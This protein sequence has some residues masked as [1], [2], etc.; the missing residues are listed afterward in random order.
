MLAVDFFV[1]VIGEGDGP[2]DSMLRM[3][4]YNSDYLLILNRSASLEFILRTN[5]FQH[6]GFDDTP[7]SVIFEW[8]FMGNFNDVELQMLLLFRCVR[9]CG[10]EPLK[11]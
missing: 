11:C 1:S 6:N 4:I 5:Y 7:L 2:P 3:S 9:W 8:T 10:G